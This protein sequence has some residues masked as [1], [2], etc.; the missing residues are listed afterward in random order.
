[1]KIDPCLLLRRQRERSKFIRISMQCHSHFLFHKRYTIYTSLFY[2]LII[3]GLMSSIVN[4]FS[5]WYTF[6]PLV[7]AVHNGKYTS[8]KTQWMSLWF[9]DVYLTSGIEVST[10]NPK[11]IHNLSSIQFCPTQWNIHLLLFGFLSFIL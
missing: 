8:G 3:Q 7:K 5:V 10:I 2:L 6:Q 11:I 9:M 1:M 4:H